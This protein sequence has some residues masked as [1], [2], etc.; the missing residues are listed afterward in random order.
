MSW[1]TRRTTT[2]ESARRA[3]LPLIC[4]LLLAALLAVF[5]APA[6]AAAYPEFE[7]FVELHSGRTIDCTLCHTHPDGPEGV[8]PGQIRSLSQEELEQLNRARAAFEP[9]SEVDSPI[10][11]DF[12]DHILHTVGKRR[13]LELRTSEPAA[14]ADELGF[15]HDLDGDGIS[16]A[17][18]YLDGTHPLDAHHGDPWLLFRHNLRTYAVHLVLILLATVLGLY[19]LNHLLAW[20]ERTADQAVPEEGSR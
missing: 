1:R 17:R 10:L 6:P 14:L 3:L 15:D 11:N 5:L 20:F 4:A 2:I 9:G 16:D 12:G 13:F 18:E 8:R 7:T 19:G